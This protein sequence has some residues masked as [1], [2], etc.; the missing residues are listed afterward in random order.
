METY[1]WIAKILDV[2]LIEFVREE[3]VKGMGATTDLSSRKFRNNALEKELMN[4]WE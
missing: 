4:L 1:L 3:Y 2:N